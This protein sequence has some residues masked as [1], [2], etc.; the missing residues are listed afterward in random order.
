[1]ACEVS[2]RSWARCL[3][4]WTR[5]SGP[6]LKIAGCGPDGGIWTLGANTF[7]PALLQGIDWGSSRVYHQINT[8]GTEAGLKMAH[9]PT[10]YDVDLPEDLA[11]LR[12]RVRWSREPALIRLGQCLNQVCGP[13]P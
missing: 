12:Q 10:W 7:C 9:L 13:I 4:R 6:R 11:A 1:M 5:R 8:A 2:P 3:P